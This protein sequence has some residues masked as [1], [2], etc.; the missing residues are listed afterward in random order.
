MSEVDC[1]AVSCPYA[2]PVADEFRVRATQFIGW[3]WLVTLN[4]A[5]VIAM[6]GELGDSARVMAHPVTAEGSGPRRL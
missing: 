1:T 4:S 6:I 5:D 2:E 3:R